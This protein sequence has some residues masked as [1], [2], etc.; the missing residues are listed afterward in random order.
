MQEVSAEDAQ[1]AGEGGKAAGDGYFLIKG[2]TE[3]GKKF[4]PSD[5]ADRLMGSV[6][7]YAKEDSEM[8]NEIL[9]S[10]CLTDRDGF[11]GFVLSS[12]IQQIE[13]MLYTFLLNFAKDNNL[14]VELLDDHEWNNDRRQVVNK[15]RQAF[16]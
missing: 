9:D 10:I 12:K 6:A 4:R 8:S 7:I 16:V 2:Q 13:P 3:E 11:K 15:P 14:K 1:V 5:W